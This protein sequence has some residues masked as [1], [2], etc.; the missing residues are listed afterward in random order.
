MEDLLAAVAAPVLAI[1]GVG[2]A[3]ADEE[4]RGGGKHAEAR[5]QLRGLDK[6]GLDGGGGARLLL[7]QHHLVQLS[8]RRAGR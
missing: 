7:L 1:V 3:C 6:A 2:A 8:P 5:T 4:S